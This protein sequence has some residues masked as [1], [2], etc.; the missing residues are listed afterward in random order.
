VVLQMASK[1]GVPKLSARISKVPAAI[2][3]H[4]VMFLNRVSVTLGLEFEGILVTSYTPE[5]RQYLC[6]TTLRKFIF[7]GC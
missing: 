3:T 7:I 1:K 5:R 2:V 4:V 6:C